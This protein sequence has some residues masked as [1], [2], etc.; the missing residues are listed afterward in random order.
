MEKNEAF[1]LNKIVR[2]LIDSFMLDNI[3]SFSDWLNQYNDTFEE[4]AKIVDN[5][6]EKTTN[7]KI[8][9]I[10]HW[11]KV[12]MLNSV[13]IYMIEMDITDVPDG[14][15]IN[16]ILKTFVLLVRKYKY[17]NIGLI[18]SKEKLYISNPETHV[19]SV[20]AYNLN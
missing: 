12:V 1:A 14:N 19:F 8:D 5:Y 16:K 10:E 17:I 20:P 9:E 6:V 13:A 3:T 4:V 2:S 15:S 7:N 11:E 18:E